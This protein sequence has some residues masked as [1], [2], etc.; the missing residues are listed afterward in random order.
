MIAMTRSHFIT[1]AA[2]QALALGALAGQSLADIEYE[3]VFIEAWDPQAPFAG[4]FA[5]GLNNLNQVSGSATVSQGNSAPFLWTLE[6]G[7]ME[8]SLYGAINDAGTIVNDNLIR[9]SDGTTLELEWPWGDSA[10]INNAG[11]VVGA[12]GNIGTCNTGDRQALVWSEA[13]GIVQLDFELG[14]QH[15]DQAWAVNESNEVVGVTS[16]TGLCGDQRAFYLDFDA[17]EHIDLADLVGGASKAYDINDNGVVVGEGPG[18]APFLWQRDEGFI[19]LP[20][21]PGGLSGASPYFS[22]NNAGQVVGASIINEE[23]WHATIWDEANG[24]RDLNDLV[25]LPPNF[26]ITEATKINDNGWII[27]WGFHGGFGPVQAVVVV[28]LEGCAADFNGDGALNILDFV[29]FQNAFTAQDPAADC[30]GNGAFNILDFVCFQGLF[31][32]GC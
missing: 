11:V 10:D 9:L 16:Q 14:I 30:D 31:Q 15:A 5:A 1:T 21:P 20:L 3:M 32:G 6:T 29:A 24:A 17:G 22:I 28:P 23:A 2:V 12:N 27:G 4:S 13:T 7:K 25:E 26:A 8:I 19:F 18:G